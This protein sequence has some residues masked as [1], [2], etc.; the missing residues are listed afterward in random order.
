MSSPARKGVGSVAFATAL[1]I[2][3][4]EG[5][6]SLDRRECHDVVDGGSGNDTLKGAAGADT[7]MVVTATTS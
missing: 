4:D 5:N 1:T 7:S 2:Q 6:D 3:G